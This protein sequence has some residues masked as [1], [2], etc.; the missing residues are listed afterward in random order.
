VAACEEEEQPALLVDFATLTGA[1]RVALGL[2][3]PALF[4]NNHTELMKIFDLS[5]SPE[6][7]D[8]VWPLP[9]WESYKS[10]LKSNIADLVNAAEG[11]GA[12]TAALYL[13][14]FVSKT[15]TAP[16]QSA[17]EGGDKEEDKEGSTSNSGGKPL[18][19][20]VDFMGTKNGMAEPQGLRT[21]YSY[22]KNHIAAK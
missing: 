1:A 17:G 7:N 2:E 4:C 11:A 16:Q 6:V 18:W 21:F 8:P 19:A 5:Q 20:H 9:L 13:Q 10:A 3:L 12:I 15:S 22:I 14:E